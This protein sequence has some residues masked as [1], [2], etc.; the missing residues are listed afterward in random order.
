MTIVALA[1][2][3]LFPIDVILLGGMRCLGDALVL[4]TIQNFFITIIGIYQELSLE[5]ILQMYIF[6]ILSETQEVAT[7]IEDGPFGIDIL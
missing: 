3:P 1:H 7:I 2:A 6:Q 5:L 4:F